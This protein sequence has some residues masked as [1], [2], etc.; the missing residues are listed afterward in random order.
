MDF[1]EYN[2]CGIINSIKANECSKDSQCN[3]QNR[4][5]K[6]QIVGGILGIDSRGMILFGF[7]PTMSV[8]EINRYRI[9]A[10]TK[11]YENLRLR[12]HHCEAMITVYKSFGSGRGEGKKCTWF[13]IFQGGGR[14]FSCGKLHR[15]QNSNLPRLLST[16][17][18]IA[19]DQP[20][21]RSHRIS[22]F[23]CPYNISIRY[24]HYL[25]HLIRDEKTR[26]LPATRKNC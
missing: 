20:A 10:K 17:L 7:F 9:I 14:S 21:V 22:Q 16:L 19:I 12:S 4:I 13:E 3:Q 25:L 11:E 2:A 8:K 15:G 24:P 5:I 23:T 6:R 26:R 18:K 1:I